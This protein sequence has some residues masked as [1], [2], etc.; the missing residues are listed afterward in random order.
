MI[1]STAYKQINDLKAENNELARLLDH[2]LKNNMLAD[3][4]EEEQE[5]ESAPSPKFM[6]ITE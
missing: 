6:S 3:N 1:C 5:V 4:K 2:L